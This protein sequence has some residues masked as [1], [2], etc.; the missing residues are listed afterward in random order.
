MSYTVITA[1]EKCKVL[2]TESQDTEL[3]EKLDTMIVSAQKKS[4]RKPSAEDVKLREDVLN[5]LVGKGQ[6]RCGA[7]ADKFKISQSKA[8]ALLNKLA[9]EKVIERTKD[10]KVT[11]FELK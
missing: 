4:V 11:Y 3:V 9:T 5:W 2:A 7:V 1:L 6:L 8:S 10:G